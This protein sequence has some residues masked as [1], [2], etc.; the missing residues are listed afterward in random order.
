MPQ[1]LRE[2]QW[3]QALLSTLQRGEDPR[4]ADNVMAALRGAD[5]LSEPEFDEWF[6]T[7]LR[8]GRWG[9]AYSRWA[10]SVA[11]SGGALPLVYNGQF[12]QPV[13]GRGFDWRLTRMPGVSVQ[14]VADAGAKGQVAHALFRGRPVAHVSLEQPLL[15]APGSYRLS[16]RVRA[17]ALR[18]DRGLEWSVTCD[19]KGE[20]LASGERLQGTFGWRTVTTEVIVPAAG[21]TGQ[22]LRLRNPAPSGSAQQVW[23]DLWFDDVSLQRGN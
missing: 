8:Q 18:S 4:A 15:L 14:F 20:P 23:G 21:C 13:S 19:G 2:P 10:G 16:A 12:E 6:A 1:W 22:W 17:D 11:L 9:E 7:L 3:R 5:G